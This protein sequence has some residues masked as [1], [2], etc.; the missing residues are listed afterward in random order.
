M[1]IT[2][3]I[4]TAIWIILSIVLFKYIGIVPIIA[5]IIFHVVNGIDQYGRKRKSIL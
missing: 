2:D 1:K 4:E 3:G 5:I